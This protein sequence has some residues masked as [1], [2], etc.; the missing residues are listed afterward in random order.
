MERLTVSFIQVCFH[1]GQI[2]KERKG[3]L[4]LTHRQAREIMSK[5]AANQNIISGELLI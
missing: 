4:P 5:I 3:L 1:S 2:K